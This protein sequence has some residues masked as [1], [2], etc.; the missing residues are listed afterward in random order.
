M[1]IK[2]EEFPQPGSIWTV[3]RQFQ[4][5]APCSLDQSKLIAPNSVILVIGREP[6]FDCEHVRM[7]GEILVINE[8]ELYSVGRHAF[9]DFCRLLK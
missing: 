6:A 2:I 7:E 3:V 9:K 4:L 5:Y 8:K 1:R